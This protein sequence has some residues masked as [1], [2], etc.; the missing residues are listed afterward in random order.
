MGTVPPPDRRFLSFIL[1]TDAL[2][3]DFV[4]SAFWTA[5]GFGPTMITLPA[6]ASCASFMAIPKGLADAG[7]RLKLRFLQ[8]F[9]VNDYYSRL[10]QNSTSPLARSRCL[11]SRS[12]QRAP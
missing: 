3:T 4:N 7:A 5:V 12:P 8:R 1:T 10:S 9:Q 11:A 2:R 6:R